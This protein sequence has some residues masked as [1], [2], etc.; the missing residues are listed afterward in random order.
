MQA[1][2]SGR[3]NVYDQRPI[4]GAYACIV[5]NRCFATKAR[6]KRHVCGTRSELEILRGPRLKSIVERIIECVT[7][8]QTLLSNLLPDTLELML[9]IALA[10]YF[11]FGPTL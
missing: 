11:A 8:N 7:S 3:G 9:F 1:F 10:V 6:L 2:S 4:I 5:C